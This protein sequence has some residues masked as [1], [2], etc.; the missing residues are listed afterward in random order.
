MFRLEFGKT[1]GHPDPGQTQMWRFS[2]VTDPPKTIEIPD[3][4]TEMN[5]VTHKLSNALSL[6]V[7][8]HLVV[9]ILSGMSNCTLL[10]TPDLN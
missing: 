6:V 3:F 10:S 1:P 8:R 4:F 5:L 7:I 9:F 2:D